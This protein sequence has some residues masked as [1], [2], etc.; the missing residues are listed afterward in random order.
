VRPR[1]PGNEDGYEIEIASIS[2]NL[3]TFSLHAQER[4]AWERDL[5][6]RDKIRGFCFSV[7]SSQKWTRL[8]PNLKI[9]GFDTFLTYILSPN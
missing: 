6:N 9:M 1:G 2:T 3:Y 5:Q 8:P 7:C 4:N